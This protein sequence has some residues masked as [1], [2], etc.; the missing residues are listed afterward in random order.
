MKT[1]AFSVKVLRT[2]I[3]RNRGQKNR[4]II[5]NPKQFKPLLVKEFFLNYWYDIELSSHRHLIKYTYFLNTCKNAN[6]KKN[7]LF[8]KDKISRHNVIQYTRYNIL[9][10]LRKMYLCLFTPRLT[11][12]QKQINQ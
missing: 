1:D 3:L 2:I 7:K 10:T 6:P 11:S 12:L 8:P 9:L 4:N 5:D